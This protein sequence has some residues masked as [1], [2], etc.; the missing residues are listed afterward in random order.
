[1]TTWQQNAAP[2]AKP[3]EFKGGHVVGQTDARGEE[4]KERPVPPRDL[5]ASMYELLGIDGN[6]RLPHP[7][8]ADVRAMPA[9]P[10][11]GPGRIA[12]IM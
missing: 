10:A 7:E 2:N 3:L 6:A 5:I 11:S 12:E 9:G 1:M 8:G 4:V